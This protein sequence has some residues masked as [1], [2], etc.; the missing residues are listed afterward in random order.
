MIDF[1]RK[2]RH[3]VAG[4]LMLL[5]ALQIPIFQRQSH[6]LGLPARIF[7]T[8][9]Y[10]P[11]AAWTTFTA[12]LRRMTNH[13]VLLTNVAA[14][15]ERLRNEVSQLR[16]RL[17][18]AQ[19]VEQENLRLRALLEMRDRNRYGAVGA[20]IIA[21][22]ASSWFH[23]FTIDVGEADGVRRG[24]PVTTHEGLVGTVVATTRNASKV[25][26]LVDMNSAVEVV[27]LRSRA[28]GILVGR[29]RQRPAINYL[30][31]SEDVRPGDVVVTSG[32][33]GTFPP[34]L[35]VGTVR[36]VRQKP[37]GLFQDAFVET[38]VKF[39]KLENV[40]VLRYVEG[41]PMP[42]YQ[43]PPTSSPSVVAAPSPALQEPTRPAQ[44][45][46]LIVAPPIA[47][48]PEPSQLESLSQTALRPATAA[49][50]P[51]RRK[52]PSP[53]MPLLEPPLTLTPDGAALNFPA[54][55]SG[56]PAKPLEAKEPPPKEPGS[57]AP[58]PPTG[59]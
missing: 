24:M 32:L 15:N 30:E 35:P 26:P 43:E 45:P 48:K 18:Q 7:Y 2:Y 40:L 59:G 16:G 55:P 37:Y 53:P 23:S 36:E 19:E 13:Y 10:Y 27:V 50:P 56:M 25:L 33:G 11:Q 51:K 34:M 39:E 47:V 49:T 20:R 9:A 58:A 54:V 22:D 38:I 31:R 5:I 28:R 12:T 41:E 42:A 29:G 3:I 4:L 1:L 17:L 8:L 44:P 21:L 6:E 52:K 57:D 46:M 14:E